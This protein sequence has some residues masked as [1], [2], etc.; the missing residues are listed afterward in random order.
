M[1]TPSIPSDGALSGFEVIDDREKDNFMCSICLAPHFDL[2][3]LSCGHTYCKEHGRHVLESNKCALCRCTDIVEVPNYLT[4]GMAACCTVKCIEKTSLVGLD[5]EE[6]YICGWIGKFADFPEHHRR[7]IVKAHNYTQSLVHTCNRNLLDCKDELDCCREELATHREELGKCQHELAVCREELSTCR[8]ELGTC[9]QDLDS[10]R[11]E[12]CKEEWAVRLL[13]DQVND[14]EGRILE[15]EDELAEEK[16]IKGLD[17]NKVLDQQ[18]QYHFMQL[19]HLTVLMAGDNGNL[20]NDTEIG[21]NASERRTTSNYTASDKIE[22]SKSC[23]HASEDCGAFRSGFD[24]EKHPDT[25][26]KRVDSSCGSVGLAPRQ[27]R[28]RCC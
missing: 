1:N 17:L 16:K 22:G 25:Q 7:C 18:Q 19:Q 10:R 20:H 13:S 3:L 28:I 27:K 8:E 11:E 26:A 2:M 23:F 6:E 21:S 14:N 5:T 24:R 9:R 12:L 4:P 15:L